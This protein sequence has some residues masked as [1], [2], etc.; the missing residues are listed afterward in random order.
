MLMPILIEEIRKPGACESG[1][2]LPHSKTL[3]KERGHNPSRQRLGV[4]QPYAALN[5][6]RLGGEDRSATEIRLLTSA[7]PHFIRLKMPIFAYFQQ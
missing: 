2:G 3:R 7:A 1:I 4:R 6:G 5:S